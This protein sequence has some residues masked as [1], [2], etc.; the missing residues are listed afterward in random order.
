VRP[1][2]PG[3]AKAACVL[4]VGEVNTTLRVHRSIVNLLLFFS[5]PLE[6]GSHRSQE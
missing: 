6:I 3:H 4:V 1:R 2:F 5:S